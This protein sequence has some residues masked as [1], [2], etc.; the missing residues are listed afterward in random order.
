MKI[1]G[2][3]PRLLSTVLWFIIFFGYR[4]AFAGIFAQKAPLA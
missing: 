4:R 3:P 2:L 1:A